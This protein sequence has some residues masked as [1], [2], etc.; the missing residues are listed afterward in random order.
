MWKQLDWIIS[1]VSKNHI[2]QLFALC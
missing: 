2:V 1:N